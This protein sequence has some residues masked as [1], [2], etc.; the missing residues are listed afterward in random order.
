[1]WGAGAPRRRCEL[2]LQGD[3]A[4]TG[5][6]RRTIGCLICCRMN[7]G[8]NCAAEPPILSA[9]PR[10]RFSNAL[11]KLGVSNQRVACTRALPRTGTPEHGETK[12][13]CMHVAL[14]CA[15]TTDADKL[16][17]DVEVPEP[18]F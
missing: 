17:T 10:W 2:L 16:R 8:G 14:D 5:Q 18:A 1:V 3:K 4:F 11:E 9:E 15:A 7:G 13:F 12:G 6:Y